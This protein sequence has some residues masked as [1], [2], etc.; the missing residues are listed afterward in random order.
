MAVLFFSSQTENRRNCQ[1]VSSRL[2]IVFWS[3]PVCQEWQQKVRVLCSGLGSEREACAWV[4]RILHKHPSLPVRNSLLTRQLST[5]PDLPWTLPVCS[6]NSF[7]PRALCWWPCCF[8]GN[9]LAIEGKPCLAGCPHFKQL[10]LFFSVR[11]GSGR[12]RTVGRAGRRH[13]RRPPLW[14]WFCLLLTRAHPFTLLKFQS[15]PQTKAVD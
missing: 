6:A 7:G 1:L 15:L 3:F 12:P 14:L 13:V 10:F 2:P 5:F 4:G 8:S 9:F 11:G